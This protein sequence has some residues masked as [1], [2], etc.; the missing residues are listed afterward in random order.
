MLVDRL[1]VVDA[2]LLVAAVP[3]REEV[4]AEVAELEAD[5]AQTERLDFFAEGL[6]QTWGSTSDLVRAILTMG[7]ELTTDS[8]FRRVVQA[9]TGKRAMET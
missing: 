1:V 3:R 9:S 4:G 8:E 2:L 6:R 7:G 5:A